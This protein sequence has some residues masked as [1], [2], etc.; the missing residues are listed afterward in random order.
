MRLLAGPLKTRRTF[1]SNATCRA[2]LYRA[3]DEFPIAAWPMRP[4]ILRSFFHLH[5]CQFRQE[6]WH[7]SR[8]DNLQYW[9]QAKPR[10]SLRGLFRRAPSGTALASLT[11]PAT[12]PPAAGYT[13]FVPQ[14]RTRSKT[15]D[16]ALRYSG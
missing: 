16:L 2:F 15:S 7:A 12:W 8:Y 6:P 9:P 4:R 13:Y 10:Q 5:L 14:C 11:S 3:R 1:A